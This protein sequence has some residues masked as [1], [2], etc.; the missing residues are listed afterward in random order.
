[1]HVECSFV[2]LSVLEKARDKREKTMTTGM[3]EK[4]HGSNLISA[5][6]LFPL[7]LF[8]LTQMQ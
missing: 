3:P 8:L 4:K 7:N 2:V 5:T 1:M 6:K